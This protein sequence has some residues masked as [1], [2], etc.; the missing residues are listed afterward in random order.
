MTGWESM[1]RRV[2]RAE[3]CA[4]PVDG[5]AHARDESGEEHERLPVWGLFTCDTAH[6]TVGPAIPLRWEKNFVCIITDVHKLGLIRRSAKQKT[7]N[8][9]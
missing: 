5:V 9:Q 4:L 3:Q 7:R 2:C 8:L 1:E 6:V